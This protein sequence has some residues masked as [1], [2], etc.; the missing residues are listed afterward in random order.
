MIRKPVVQ[1]TF[2]PNNAIELKNQIENWYRAYQPTS[3]PKSIRALIVPHAGYIF[4]G[5]V[6]ARAY[7]QLEPSAKYKNVFLI[8]RSH[9]GYFSGASVYPSGAF[10]NALGEVQVNDTICEELLKYK[11][12]SQPSYYHDKEHALEVQIPFLQLRLAPDFRI[13]PILVGTENTT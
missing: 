3:Y 9:Q 6:A 2:Y 8:G 10:A 5:A 4:S 12:F 1:G 11:I 13:V 7:A